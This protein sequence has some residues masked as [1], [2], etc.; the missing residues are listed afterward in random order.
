VIPVSGM[1]PGYLGDIMRF[2]LSMLFLALA[3]SCGKPPAAGRAA[4]GLA[5]LAGPTALLTQFGVPRQTLSRAPAQL[6]ERLVARVVAGPALTALVG[7][8]DTLLVIGV[9]G[10]IP[11]AIQPGYGVLVLDQS[12]KARG[13]MLYEGLPV[14]GAPRIGTVT[15][16]PAML[17]LIGLQVDPAKIEDPRCPL[18]PDSVLP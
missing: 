3:T 6:P 16:G 18:F 7:R 13:L 5:A 12:E 8:A 2:P 11:P 15:V 14:E 10:A 1:S 9:E 17:P 4:C